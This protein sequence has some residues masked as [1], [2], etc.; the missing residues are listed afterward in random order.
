[1][2]EPKDARRL[3]PDPDNELEL[4]ALSTAFPLPDDPNFNMVSPEET[5]NN[6][7]DWVRPVVAMKESSWVQSQ[8]PSAKRARHTLGPNPNA[9]ALLG[10]VA[11]QKPLVAPQAV[12]PV[13]VSSSNLPGIVATNK[14]PTAATPREASAAVALGAASTTEASSS[15][16]SQIQGMIDSNNQM[17]AVAAWRA[18]MGELQHSQGFPISSDA[19]LQALVALLRARSS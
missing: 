5:V 10:L 9:Y 12:L 8:R 13:P 14:S 6:P 3:I 15:I 7:S 16:L 4:Y 1:M 11:A 18:S 19:H 17:L 2:P